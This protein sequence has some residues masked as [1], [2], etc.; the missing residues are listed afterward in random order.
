MWEKKVCD[1]RDF[2]QYSIVN[3]AYIAM[4]FFQYHPSLF[5]IIVSNKHQVFTMEELNVEKNITIFIPARFL[6]TKSKSWFQKG[7]ETSPRE[8]EF[9][10]FA[11]TYSK[12]IHDF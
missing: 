10:S 5:P 12:E 1:N 9:L 3:T 6:A 7:K 11:F 8:K 4:K 2:F